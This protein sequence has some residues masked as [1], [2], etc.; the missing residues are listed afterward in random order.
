MNKSWKSFDSLIS[1]PSYRKSTRKIPLRATSSASRALAQRKRIIE[2]DTSKLD[3]N[4]TCSKKLFRSIQ[5]SLLD[6]EST[7]EDASDDEKTITLTN[8]SK[9]VTLESC[10]PSL[11]IEEETSS[12]HLLSDIEDVSDGEPSGMKREEILETES[13]NKSDCESIRC[14]RTK[15]TRL[16]FCSPR[17]HR[18]IRRITDDVFVISNAT[19]R[20]PTSEKSHRLKTFDENN[21]EKRFPKTPINQQ[22]SAW[23]RLNESFKSPKKTIAANRISSSEKWSSLNETFKSSPPVEIENSGK[24]PKDY[25][26]EDVDDI[27]IQQVPE[28]NQHSSELYTNR[29]L[30]YPK[31][32]TPKVKFHKLSGFMNVS[33]A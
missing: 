10:A 13:F 31:P 8:R 32:P 17:T 1:T 21:L 5:G 28:S 12:K 3:E 15:V 33:W 24:S 14:K 2:N 11:Q 6:D 26:I 16:D 19:E 4:S 29:D 9:E 18:C 23:K 30:V 22:G 25:E 27:I 7:I 20:E